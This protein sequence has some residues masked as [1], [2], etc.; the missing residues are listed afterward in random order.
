MTSRAIRG[1]LCRPRQVVAV[2]SDQPGRIVMMQV[3][4]II[5]GMFAPT[6]GDMAPWLILIGLK[7]LFDYQRADRKPA[8]H[9]CLLWAERV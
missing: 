8:S 2:S 3:A 1:R 9:R 6:C 7:T 5:G 4:A